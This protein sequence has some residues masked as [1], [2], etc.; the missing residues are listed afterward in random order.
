MR[1]TRKGGSENRPS[2]TIRGR[3]FNNENKNENVW[4]IPLNRFNI[5]KFGP[6]NNNMYSSSNLR[7]AN[8]PSPINDEKINTMP[9]EPMNIIKNM[10][11]PNTRKRARNN[12]R[13]NRNRNRTRKNMK[14]HKIN[15]RNWSKEF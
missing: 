1:K 15:N 5:K 12:N 4:E 9:Y 2:L 13:N 8:K 7:W 3:K 10:N 11:F 14:K 6:G